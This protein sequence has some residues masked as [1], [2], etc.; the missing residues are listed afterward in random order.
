M[1]IH[2]PEDAAVPCVTVPPP[3]DPPPPQPVGRPV[4]PEIFNVD[5][6]DP[7]MAAR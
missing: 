2:G 5:V 1:K 3:L 4:P 6:L 7:V